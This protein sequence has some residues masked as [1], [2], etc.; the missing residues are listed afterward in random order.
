MP[1]MISSLPALCLFT[2]LPAAALAQEVSVESQVPDIALTA[3]SSL[4]ANPT[5]LAADDFCL[6]SGDAESALAKSVAAAGWGV[7]GEQ[8][9]NGY[10]FIAFVGETEDGT[11]G[12][13]LLNKGN[14]GIFK[15]DRIVALL[16]GEGERTSA[17]ANVT[18]LEAGGL[19]VWDG[20]YLSRPVGDLHVDDTGLIR[21]GPIAKSD[22][23]C[24][25]AVEVPTL[26]DQPIDV[27]REGLVKSGWTPVPADAESRATWSD[28]VKNQVAG[29]LE[30]LHDCSPTG[31]GYCSYEYSRETGQRL[32]V[33]TAGEG[34]EGR[35]PLIADYLVS[36]E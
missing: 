12:S 32:S 10:N 34:A 25:G 19:R 3:V 27:A 13:C 5:P 24:Q 33:T 31:F 18:P 15:G 17:V 22:T 1:Q 26:Y 7:M 8:Q 36:C 14:I 28:F 23:F 35:G 4:P 29:G 6:N 9:K 30:E 16:Y 21:F 2:L 20:D 11:S